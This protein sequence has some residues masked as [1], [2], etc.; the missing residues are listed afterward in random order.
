MSE[1]PVSPRAAILAVIG[2]KFG[3]GDEYA[4]DILQALEDG[5]FLP[6][7][8]TLPKRMRYAAIV[9]EEASQKHGT[10]LVNTWAPAGLRSMADEF[11]AKDRAKAELITTI[12]NAYEP[13]IAGVRSIASHVADGLIESGWRKGD[14]S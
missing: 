8:S 9:L 2:N 14:P 3:S 4:T 11:D 13:Y 7:L 12:A 1:T 10:D 6:D 5:G